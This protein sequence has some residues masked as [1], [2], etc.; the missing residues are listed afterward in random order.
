[1]MY[2][3]TQNHSVLLFVVLFLFFSCQIKI[4]TFQDGYEIIHF[5]KKDF[6]VRS[7]LT[8][9]KQEENPFWYPKTLLLLEDYL[10]VG[11]KFSDTLLHILNRSDLRQIGVVGINGLG[12]Q[13]IGYPFRIYRD[14]ANKNA[15][16]AY[17]VE[18]RKMLSRFIA[19]E[20]PS[21]YPD[22]Q[23]SLRDSLYFMMDFTFSSDSTLLGFGA[24][25]P[26]KFHEFSINTD[27]RIGHWGRWDDLGRK[28][29]PGNVTMSLFSGKVAVNPTRDL[30]VVPS[31][32][33]DH[34]E[35]FDKSTGR[36]FGLRGPDQLSPEVMVDWSLS[37][38]MLACNG[39]ED[40]CAYVKVL[41][42]GDFIYALYSGYSWL[43]INKYHEKAW[44][45][46]LVFRLDGTPSA[47]YQLDHQVFDF[48][49]DSNNRI[50][51][52]ITAVEEDPNLVTFS[53]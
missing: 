16:W 23:L 53:Y 26:V 20:C 43:D 30:F 31:G 44:D 41:I 37:Y 47:Y 27:R 5:S 12:P 32:R 40:R 48:E 36:Q 42:D 24:N 17:D 11:E 13:E 39:I 6:P 2:K 19:E 3:R 34:L 35:V 45:K 29:W 33:I 49:I 7:N 9:K 46:I 18:G 50:I 38:P 25:G 51:Y 4:E 8:G 21:I 52:G 10:V 22:K 14:P 28:G 15:F 1:M